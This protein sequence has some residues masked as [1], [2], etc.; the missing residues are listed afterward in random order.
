MSERRRIISGSKIIGPARYLVI[1]N[2]LLHPVLTLGL[3]HL[4]ITGR[5]KGLSKQL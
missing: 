3:S 5:K 4:V 1:I 2:T